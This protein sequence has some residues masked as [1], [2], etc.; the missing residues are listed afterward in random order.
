M[1]HR[2][3]KRDDLWRLVAQISR[4]NSR[5]A[6][7]A[8]HALDAGEVDQ[9]LDSPDALEA[10][11]GHGGPPAPLPLTLLWYVPIRAT[12]RRWGIDDIDLADFTATLPIL[13]ST[14]GASR[15]IARG[16]RGVA[17]WA[18]SIDS[19]PPET[20]GRAERSAECGALA[21][22]WAGCF[23]SAVTRQGGLS[24]IRA[25]VSFA[26]TAITLAGSMIGGRSPET[27]AFYS[28]VAE[29]AIHVRAALDEVRRD[30]LDPYGTSPDGRVGRFLD[31]ITNDPGG[32]LSAA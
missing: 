14:T 18:N 21:L 5:A 28:R 30:Y 15:R 7:P 19:M 4:F 2:W 23:P 6:R 1:I 24:S 22:W 12:L 17:A 31:R 3:L 9:L 11:L 20:L 25:Y 32:F 10:V 13:F 29:N 8:A 26:A 16:E 27:A